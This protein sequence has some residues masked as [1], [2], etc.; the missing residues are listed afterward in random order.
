MTHIKISPTD[1]DSYVA[2]SENE[3]RNENER[4]AFR[5]AKV[6]GFVINHGVLAVRMDV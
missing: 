3:C 6:C 4:E 1:I 5:M 2:T